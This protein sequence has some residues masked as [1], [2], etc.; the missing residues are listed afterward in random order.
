MS[1]GTVIAAINRKRLAISNIVS[2]N[3]TGI[4]NL[5]SISSIGSK[6]QLKAHTEAM[7]NNFIPGMFLNPNFLS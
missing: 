7:R 6:T 5:F 1:K 4:D 2:F 3:V